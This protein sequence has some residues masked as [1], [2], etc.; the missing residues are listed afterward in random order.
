MEAIQG[1]NASIYNDAPERWLPPIAP[2]LNR[3]GFAKTCNSARVW[4]WAAQTFQR[5]AAASG[6]PEPFFVTRYLL[7]R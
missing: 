4:C 6:S 7:Y 2:L 3:H 1:A 5:P